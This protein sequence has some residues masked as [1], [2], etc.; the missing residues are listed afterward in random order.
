MYSSSPD[1]IAHVC[2]VFVFFRNIKLFIFH[3]MKWKALF[4]APLCLVSKWHCNLAGSIQLICKIYYTKTYLGLGSIFIAIKG[5][6]S[7]QVSTIMLS[8]LEWLC[9]S[10]FVNSEAGALRIGLRWDVC[11]LGPEQT[12]HTHHQIF[13]L[14]IL[15]FTSAIH[16]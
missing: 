6:S 16:C 9:V 7:K 14:N 13:F 10:I 2:F 1:F 3:G 15:L 4:S 11:Y 5:D 8:C 12:D